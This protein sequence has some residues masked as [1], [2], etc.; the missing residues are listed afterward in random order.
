MRSFSRMFSTPLRA[1]GVLGS[2]FGFVSDFLQPIAPVGYYL[3]CFCL[4]FLFIIICIKLIP[5]LDGF[6]KN[7][8]ESVWFLPLALTLVVFSGLLATANF[9]SETFGE[10]NKGVI[11]SHV[12]ALE[13]IQLNLVVGQ[14]KTFAPE[15]L[16]TKGSLGDVQGGPNLPAIRFEDK[17]DKDSLG[18][19]F[20]PNSPTIRVKDKSDDALLGQDSSIKPAEGTVEDVSEEMDYGTVEQLNESLIVGDI[21]GIENFLASGGDLTLL[22]SPLPEFNGYGDSIIINAIKNNHMTIDKVLNYL[23]KEGVI[24]L[25]DLFVVCPYSGEGNKFWQEINKVESEKIVKENND[26]Y[27]LA[28]RKYRKELRTARLE[29]I[30]QIPCNAFDG[31]DDISRCEEKRKERIELILSNKGI[32]EP[33]MNDHLRVNPYNS[34]PSMA[35]NTLYNEAVIAGNS[36]AIKFLKNSGVTLSKDGIFV[37]ENG[38]TIPVPLNKTYLKAD[39]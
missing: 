23:V 12:P 10:D 33:K 11:S 6:L 18:Q 26:S 37:L 30:S 8:Y 24:R 38:T 9:V 34:S 20:E 39:L 13:Q 27:K 15:A 21:E 29:A 2:I 19:D 35:K 14:Y 36:M 17:S 28:N 25:E 32:S 16:R 31:D 3:S 1:G 7:R 22:K 4:A 5:V